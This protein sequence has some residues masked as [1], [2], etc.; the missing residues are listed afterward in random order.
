MSREIKQSQLVDEELINVNIK[1]L[2]LAV[3]TCNSSQD[4]ISIANKYRN[5]IFNNEDTIKTLYKEI[6]D[7]KFRVNILQIENEDLLNKLN[8]N[9]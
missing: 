7:L 8:K 5:F 3:K 4:C 9:P 1:A 6:D 2:E